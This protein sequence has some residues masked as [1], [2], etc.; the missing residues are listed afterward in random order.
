[1]WTVASTSPTPA[2]HVIPGEAERAAIATPNVLLVM[3]AGDHVSPHRS[4]APP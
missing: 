2:S 3:S 4:V 1:M